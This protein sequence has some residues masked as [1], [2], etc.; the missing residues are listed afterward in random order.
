[1]IAQI[2][3]WVRAFPRKLSVSALSAVWL[4]LSPDGFGLFGHGANAADWYAGLALGGNVSPDVT[5]VSRSN[6][7]ASIRDEFINPLGVCAVGIRESENSLSPR[8]WPID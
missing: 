4:A 1:M 8:P 7:R 6:D 5:V 2:F 3:G